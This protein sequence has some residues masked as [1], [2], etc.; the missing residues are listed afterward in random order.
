M[1]PNDCSTT[2]EIE[3]ESL[4]WGDG[5]EFPFSKSDY[6]KAVE[7][8][9]QLSLSPELYSHI[10]MRALRRVIQPLFNLQ[11][12]KM[13]GGTDPDTL[14]VKQMLKRRR[15]Q[16]RNKQKAD[17]KANL[18]KTK[19]RASRSTRL[20]ELMKQDALT[21]GKGLENTFLLRDG[22]AE[23]GFNSTILPSDRTCKNTILDVEH[24]I[25][26]ISNESDAPNGDDV[27]NHKIIAPGTVSE[28]NL[29]FDSYHNNAHSCGDDNEE[30]SSRRNHTEKL[31][32]NN[33]QLFLLNKS[34]CCYSCK[35]KFREIHH[36]YDKL[37]PE[38]ATL[39]F[40]KRIQMCNMEGRVCLVTGG[41]V[42]IGFQTCLK[43]L[44]CGAVVI[45]TSRF[46]LDTAKR[47]SEQT[48]FQVRRIY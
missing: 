30:E 37:C 1:Q 24:S 33:D 2:V 35:N 42:K 34:I 41:R 18:E 19:I 20:G 46:P 26:A 25:N 5:N 16:E 17:D 15:A 9:T 10:E 12:E 31:S 7:V 32:K 21:G 23:D 22:I 28:V 29:D 3:A 8:I 44:R 45:V 11:K 4:I 36:F 13:F 14:G 6:I 38:C 47:F 27:F 40:Q 39:N 43:L 48:D